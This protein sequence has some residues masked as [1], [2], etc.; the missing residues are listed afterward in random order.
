MLQMLGTISAALF[1]LGF[2]EHYYFFRA[3]LEYTAWEDM[4]RRITASSE[5]RNDENESEPTY[6]SSN[7][8]LKGIQSHS[9]CASSAV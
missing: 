6:R 5:R 1:D 3:Q 9:G 2:E 8:E 7:P 4:M